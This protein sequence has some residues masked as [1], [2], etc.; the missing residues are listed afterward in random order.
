ML[1]FSAHLLMLE[2]EQFIGR[3]RA[4]IAEG[5]SVLRLLVQIQDEYVG[6]FSK[7]DVP[8]VREK[9]LDVKDL[10]PLGANLSSE[11]EKPTDYQGTRSRGA[12]ARTFSSSRQKKG[13]WSYVVVSLRTM[14]LY[15]A[16]FKYRWFQ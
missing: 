16:R 8:M 14:R 1:I 7:S 10:K 9:V 5:C 2:D 6:L 3:I 12:V 13:D 11:H 4:Q 15:A